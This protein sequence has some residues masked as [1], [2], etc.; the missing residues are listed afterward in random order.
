M[1]FDAITGIAQAEDAAKV[2]VSYAGAQAEQLI[3]DTEKA[4]RETVRA[5]LEKAE[6][7]LKKLSE[8]SE[9]RSAETA[10]KLSGK[11]ENKKAVLQAAAESRMD[12][13]AMLI[14]ERI[15]NG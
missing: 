6:G 5:A 1:S 9:L 11:M 10:G 7:E 14:V 15:V 3:A 4:G 2:A 13:A 12:K 8:Q